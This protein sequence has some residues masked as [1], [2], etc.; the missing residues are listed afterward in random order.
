MFINLFRD[1][2]MQI[3]FHF[4][5]TYVNDKSLGD[6]INRLRV[7]VFDFYITC[8]WDRVIKIWFCTK[9]VVV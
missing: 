9:L 3:E 4:R 5:R 8:I 1:R 6:D 7:Y 2:D